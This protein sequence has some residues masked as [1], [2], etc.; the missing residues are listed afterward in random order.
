[1]F[2]IDKTDTSEKY[3]FDEEDFINVLRELKIQEN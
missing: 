1:L 3:C 2:L